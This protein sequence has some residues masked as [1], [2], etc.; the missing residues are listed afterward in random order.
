MNG[1]KTGMTDRR[2][3]E[4]LGGDGDGPERR[5]ESGR[6]LEGERGEA[7]RAL[8]LMSSEMSLIRVS[9]SVSPYGSHVQGRHP[10]HRIGVTSVSY[11]KIHA[12]PFKLSQCNATLRQVHIQYVPYS[13]KHQ[14]PGII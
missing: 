14:K 5:H 6:G 13:I 1:D 10:D 3:K 2:E 4:K 7:M 9:L 8:S 11:N 12:K